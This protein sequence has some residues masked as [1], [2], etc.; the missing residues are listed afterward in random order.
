MDSLGD[1]NWA[2]Y[3][4]DINQDGYIDAN[5]F[6]PYDADNHSAVRFVYATTDFNGDGY[7]DANDYP[8]FDGNN[9]HGVHLIRP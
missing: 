2:F 8:V 3:T 7:V 5:D 1:G 9:H 4:G 6:P